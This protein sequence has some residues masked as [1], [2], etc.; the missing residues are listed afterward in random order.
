MEW[1]FLRMAV[2]EVEPLWGSLGE[3]GR[4]ESVISSMSECDDAD[5]GDFFLP[6]ACLKELLN[7]KSK[8][9]EVHV[10]KHNSK[11]TA[12]NQTKTE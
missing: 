7:C 1:Q 2:E 5:L 12:G 6:N 11:L 10:S 8:E 4:E 9:R 3:E